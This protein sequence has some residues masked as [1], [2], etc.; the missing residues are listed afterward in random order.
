MRK[1]LVCGIAVLI[2]GGLLFAA[3]PQQ[4]PPPGMMQGRMGPMP[5]MAQNPLA[6]STMLAFVLPDMQSELGLSPAQVAELGRLRTK[7]MNQEQT[8]S[9][10]IAAALCANMTETPTPPVITDLSGGGEDETSW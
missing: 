6:R 1:H 10:E 7:F 8:T 5:G 9:T 3:E 2:A 4:E